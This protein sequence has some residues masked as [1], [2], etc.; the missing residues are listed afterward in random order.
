MAIIVRGMDTLRRFENWA[1]PVVLVAAVALLVYM[2]TEA[3]GFGNVLSEPAKL[4]WGG[5]FWPVFFYGGL[6]GAVAGVLITDYWLI[7]R[8]DLRLTDLY[9]PHGD[10][11]YGGGWNWR[12][13]VAF[14]A[15]ALL[16]VGGAWSAPGQ[17]PVPAGRADPGAQAALRLQLGGG[18]RGRDRPVLGPDPRPPRAGPRRHGTACLNPA[19]VRVDACG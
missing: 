5:K 7:R 18:L 3:H 9:R 6:L 11:W 19:G 1:A 4:G 2:V 12:A 10:Y 8:T 15:G 14:A 16:T 17:G 13:V